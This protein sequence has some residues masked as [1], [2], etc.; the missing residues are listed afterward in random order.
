MTT[1]IKRSL[2]VVLLSSVAPALSF[3]QG[4]DVGLT[5][6]GL[7]SLQPIDDS[8]VGG[9]YL[10]EGIGGVAPGFGVAFNAVTPSGLVVRTELTTA[11][12]EQ[13]QSGRLVPGSDGGRH[14]VVTTLHD[15]IVSALIGQAVTSGRTRFEFVAGVGMVIDS[16]MAGDIDIYEHGGDDPSRFVLTGGIDML[17]PVG[18]RAG[19]TLTARYSHLGRI[20]Q[21]QYLGIGPHIFRFGAGLRVKVN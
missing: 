9:P 15:T 1:W 5:G 2:I 8:Y 16:P 20:E 10:D 3:A 11:R 12:F 19:F 7:L 17:H 6:V 4:A 14:S 21:A 13:E 18:S